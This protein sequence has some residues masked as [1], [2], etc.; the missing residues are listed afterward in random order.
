MVLRHPPTVKTLHGSGHTLTRSAPA[1]RVA[2]PSAL[3]T[4]ARERG[5]PTPECSTLP[6]PSRSHTLN[7]R[8]SALQIG[9]P[10]QRELQLE[11]SG[12][13][14]RPARVV[15]GVERVLGGRGYAGLYRARRGSVGRVGAAA[16]GIWRTAYLALGKRTRARLPGTEAR[17][18]AN[19]IGGPGNALARLGGE[20]VGSAQRS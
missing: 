14:G 6:S 11:D 17:Q 9:S 1:V 3:Q 16:L 15:R 5:V 8:G 12:L 18:Q 10:T 4:H 19:T 7:L 13:P 2:A 20:C